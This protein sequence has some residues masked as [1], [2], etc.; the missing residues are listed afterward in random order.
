M[1]AVLNNSRKLPVKLNESIHLW[2]PRHI[3]VTR[4]NDKS[5][6]CLTPPVVTTIDDFAESQHPLTILLDSTLN[7]RIQLKQL[8]MATSRKDAL[9]PLTD[10]RVVTERSVGSILIQ[11]ALRELVWEWLLSEAHDGGR[12][13]AVKVLMNGC[14]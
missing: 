9:Y 14:V 2:E 8:L 12:D 13:V 11:T 6:E 7:C 4:C 1:F 5:I 3:V 10:S